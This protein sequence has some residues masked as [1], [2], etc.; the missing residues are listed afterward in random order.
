MN[1]LD[2]KKKVA[3]CL[4]FLQ[5]A[6]YVA[7]P[8]PCDI[9]DYVQSIVIAAGDRIQIA[10]DIL[11]FDDFFVDDQKLIFDEKA[12]GK[13]ILKPEDAVELLRGLRE[14]LSGI[15]QFDIKTTEVVVKSFVEERGIKIGQ[16][17][18]ALRVAV[19]GKGVGFGTFDTLA[20]LGRDRCLNRIDLAIARAE[21]AG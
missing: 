20:I 7:T 13:R 19:T 18:N 4:P 3:M 10:G 9:S 17:I 21:S 6:N 1:E 15:E 8:P 12:F 11:D 5:K 16:I 2:L 14:K